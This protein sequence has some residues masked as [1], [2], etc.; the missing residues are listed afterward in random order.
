[1]FEL[2]LNSMN[3]EWRK[4]YTIVIQDSNWLLM[5]EISMSHQLDAK[6]HEN[7]VIREN[8]HGKTNEYRFL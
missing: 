5:A 7:V 1:M 4:K 3:Q 2:L 8:S 6:I